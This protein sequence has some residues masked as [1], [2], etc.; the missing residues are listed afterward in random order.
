M[1]NFCCAENLYYLNGLNLLRRE[2]KD[3]DTDQTKDWLQPLLISLLI[4]HENAYRRKIDLPSLTPSYE[5]LRLSTMMDFVRGGHANPLYEWET[6]NEIA[7]A[8][9]A[10]M[11]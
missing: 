2:F 1:A 9:Y 8:K 6:L 4:F 11:M 10:E 3:Y 7:H 5:A